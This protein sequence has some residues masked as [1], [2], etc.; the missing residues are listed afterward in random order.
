MKH[1][2]TPWWWDV[3]SGLTRTGNGP[4]DIDRRSCVG[5]ANREFLLSACNNH[6]ALVT[7][8]EDSV[9]TLELMK[10]LTVYDPVIELTLGIANSALK[11]AGRG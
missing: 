1:E 3:W 10:G 6:D 5:R 2:A 11:E 9:K 7:A 8:L 4:L